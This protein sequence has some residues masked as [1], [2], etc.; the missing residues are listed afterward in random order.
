M[1]IRNE[2]KRPWKAPSIALLA[3]SEA[4]G[5]GTIAP[6]FEVGMTGGATLN[7]TVNSPGSAALM[8]NMAT[9][10]LFVSGPS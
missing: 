4:A 10:D 5:G 1:G 8:A 7:Y 9:Y 6:T 3:G 2:N